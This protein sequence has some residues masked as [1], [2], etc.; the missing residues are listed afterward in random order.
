MGAGAGKTIEEG[1]RESNREKLRGLSH[2]SK[3]YL[4]LA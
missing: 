3:Q 2:F 4:Y 1:R